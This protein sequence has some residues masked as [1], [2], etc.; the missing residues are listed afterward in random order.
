[1][2]K[3]IGNVKSVR[4]KILAGFLVVAA[5]TLVVSVFSITRMSTLA[6]K[7]DTLDKEGVVALVTLGDARVNYN[8][9]RTQSVLHALN[10]D[11]KLMQVAED[12]VAE[13]RTAFAAAMTSYEKTDMTGREKLVAD[14]HKTWAE[15]NTVLDDHLFVAS[16]AGDA[17]AARRIID[18]D[19]T[20]L[21]DELTKDFNALNVIEVRAAAALA[22]D[23]H[24]AYTSART[25]TIG[26]AALA[27]ALAIA[28][29]FFLASMI[30]KPLRRTVDVLNKVAEGDLTIR[31]DVTSKDEVGQAGEALN[32]TLERTAAVIASIGENATSLAGSSEELSAVSQQLGASAEET[33]AQSGAVASAAE[34][35]SANINTVAAGTEEMGASINE[36]AS[37][38]TEAARVAGNAVS[39]AATATST[40]T[41]LGESSVEIGEVIKVITSIAEQTNLLALNA[42]IEAARAGEAGKG[43]A[44]VANEVK[45]LAKQ[46]ADATDN[47]SGRVTTIQTDA[48]AAT[49]AIGEITEVI[50]R[51]NEIQTSIAGAV[52]EQTATTN[53]IGRSVTEAATGASDIA[54]NVAGVAQA[55]QDT[56]SGAANTLV[57]AGE[58][59][60]MAEELRRLVGQFVI[61]PARTTTRA[62][63]VPGTQ[64]ALTASA[65]V[66][67]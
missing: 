63:P 67:V 14:V 33:S 65:P 62:V 35:V 55:S 56:A 42:T 50:N 54:R 60:R 51:I 44:V 12:K 46:T 7:A 24:S 11:P 3:L 27:L 53:E 5:I 37:S 10:V 52:E 40:V 18:Q 30:T 22:H 17:D 58:L 48:Q 6:G 13:Y 39:V 16:R 19:T 41:K 31:L 47:I 43:F 36:I 2:T 4:T 8:R 38:A 45:E 15:Y 1:L 9:I 61:T 49:A 59:A 32:R 26:I 34:E 23:A 21:T 57:A 25:M 28:L 66:A 64:P 29:G 20:P